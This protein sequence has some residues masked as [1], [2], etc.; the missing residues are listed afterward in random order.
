MERLLNVASNFNLRRY[1]QEPNHKIM[2]FFPTARNTQLAAELFGHMR[3][4]IVEIH[5]RKSQSARTKAGCCRLTPLGLQS[6]ALSLVDFV[7]FF[8]A[9]RAPTR[10]H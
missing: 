1:A 7:F 6:T 8:N 5:S 4:D 10:S 2:C 9:H 3:D